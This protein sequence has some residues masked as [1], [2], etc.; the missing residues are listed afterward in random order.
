V[1]DT[2]TSY[3]VPAAADPE[4]ESNPSLG[5]PA[6]E[7]S[8]LSE[9]QGLVPLDLARMLLQRFGLVIVWLALAVV[10]GITEHDQFLTVGTFK[11]IFGSQQ[12]LVFLALALVCTFSV[13]EFDLSVSG[14]LG[15]SATLVTVLN[16]NHDVNIGVAS[17]L[18]IGAA[19]LIGTINGFLVV[20]LGIDAIVTT[21]G[22]STLLLGVALAVANAQ[23]VG[24]LTP[25]FGQIAFTEFG[26]LPISFY[27][28]IV[29]AGVFA[30]ILAATPLGRHLT[31]VGENREVAR[32]AGINVNRIRFGAYLTSS[33]ICGVG[34]VLLAA[35]VGG[36]DPQSST[37][38]LLPAF[39]ATFLGTVVVVPG[40]FN[41]LGAIIAIY[42]LVTGIVG[43]Q[44]LGYTG[45]ISQVFFGGSLIVAVSLSRLLRTAHE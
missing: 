30:Y 5:G 4:A 41:P 20:K 19:L 7:P 24:G 43:L 28:G 11:T 14:T 15:L 10:Y 37:G 32:L 40:R 18:A 31:F 8:G 21:L 33:L 22:M 26:G 3:E 9:R 2:I 44:L 1:S 16:V 17:L 38:Y 35:G 36:F 6:M 39:A 34:G 23:A 25:D 12:P 13:G 27:Y 45:W 29:I 42:F